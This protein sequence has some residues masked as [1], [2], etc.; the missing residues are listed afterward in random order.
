MSSSPE[1]ELLV[2]DVRPRMSCDLLGSD[3]S[4]SESKRGGS[5]V[6]AEHGCSGWRRRK[7]SRLEGRSAV[8]TNRGRPAGDKA[9]RARSEENGVNSLKAHRFE[10]KQNLGR[11]QDG[12]G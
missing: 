1:N 9:F 11:E 2:D 3:E 4:E 8:K 6:E 7:Q 5:R 12:E 10:E